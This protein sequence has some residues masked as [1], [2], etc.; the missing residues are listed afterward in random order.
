MT[1]ALRTLAALNAAVLAAAVIAAPL[2]AQDEV[3]GDRVALVIG[4]EDY[5]GAPNLANAVRDARDMADLLRDFGFTVYEGYD[6]DRREFETLLRTTM[7]NLSDGA[8]VVFFYAGHGIQIG[9]RNYLLPV[10]VAF[11]SVYDLPTYSITLD[12]VIEVLSARGSTHVA[13]IDACRENPFPN[14]RLAAE[15]DANLFETQAGFD[16]FRTPLN[17]VVAFSTSPGELAFDGVEGGNSPYTEAVLTTARQSPDESI[18]TLFSEVREK[19]YTATAGRQVPWESSTL[20]RPFRLL[21]QTA[22]ETRALP[23]SAPAPQEERSTAQPIS[24]SVTLPLDR[25][26]PLRQ[27]LQ[28]AID[29]PLELPA[30]VEPPREGQVSVNLDI[31]EISYRPE[32]TEVRAT[33][34]DSYTITDLFQLELGPENDRRPVTVELTLEAHACDLEAGDALDLQ[35]VGLYRLPNEIEQD[36]AIAA[37]T[38][39]LEAAPDVARF[40]YQLGRAQQATGDFEAALTSFRVAGEAGHVRAYNAEAFL[41]ITEHVD[42]DLVPIPLDLDRAVEL[43]EAG[44]AAGD[45]FAMHARGTRLLREGDTPDERERGFELL[46]RAAELGHTYSMNALGTYFLTRDSEYY[47]PERGMSY[48]NASSTRDDIYGHHNLG[49]VALLGLDGSDPDYD[50]A[51]RYFERAALGGHPNS[52][53]TLG[54]MIMRGQLDTVDRAAAVQWYDMGLERGDGWGGANAASIILGGGVGGMGPAHAAV[55][56]AK[57]VHLPARDAAE[58]A[59]ETLESLDA[60]TIDRALQMILVELGESIAV[61]G[62]V[63]PGTRGALERVLSRT[64]LSLTDDS[65]RGRLLVAARAYW[66][67]RPVRPDLY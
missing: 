67:E 11:G 37:C 2:H 40:R 18:L 19:V 56:A 20:V 21:D 35:G 43:L 4:N 12:R 41:L 36:A 64:G 27:P 48:F 9:R 65:P 51:R 47:Q 29:Q 50:R 17:S 44:I 1:R 5:A 59:Q 3:P 16:V 23:V 61:D 25:R 39:A 49:I 22:Q 54:R 63:G 45:P 42:R 34:L 46:D 14:L 62:Q 8:D 32:L 58:A 55:R 24:V 7:L 28:A 10:D 15:L 30:V 33:A 57:A 66:A 52:P 31:D 6:V 38:A 60:R 26:I 13:M 53:A